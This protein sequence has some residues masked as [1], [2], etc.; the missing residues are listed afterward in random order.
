MII[1]VSYARRDNGPHALREIEQVVTSLGIPYVDDV[2]SHDATDRRAV[3]ERA[4]RVAAVFVGVVSPN[5]LQTP[6]TRHEFALAVYQ[7]IPVIA[8]LPNGRLVDSAAVDWPWRHETARVRRMSFLQ[9]PAT[10]LTYS[11]KSIV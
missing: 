10:L 5:Y 8:F 11:P 9:A 1:F 4:L 2:H 3:V 6:W 7:G